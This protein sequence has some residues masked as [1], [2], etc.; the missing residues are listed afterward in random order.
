[1]EISTSPQNLFFSERALPWWSSPYSSCA[2]PSLFY[3]PSRPTY[4]IRADKSKVEDDQAK[5]LRAPNAHGSVRSN[6][7]H[8][9]IISA[10]CDLSSSQICFFD[11]H[12]LIP[13]QRKYNL[14]QLYHHRAQ[15]LLPLEPRIAGQFP[16]VVAFYLFIM[17]YHRER[18]PIKRRTQ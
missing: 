8:S 5:V 3:G 15:S 12:A 10:L 7:H 2:Q 13:Y 11:V 17:T 16:C 1:M 6:L 18:H 14:H 9:I 4:F